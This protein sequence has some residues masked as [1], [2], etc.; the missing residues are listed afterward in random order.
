MLPIKDALKIKQALS[1][2]GFNHD[3]KTEPERKGVAHALPSVLVRFSLFDVKVRNVNLYFGKMY[4][5]GDSYECNAIGLLRSIAL[6]F[7]GSKN[8]KLA[9]EI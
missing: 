8:R 2:S 9:K 5:V 6:C 3:S 1:E 4:E 7:T